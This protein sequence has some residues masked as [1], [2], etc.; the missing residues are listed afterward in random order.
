M[1]GIDDDLIY[2]HSKRAI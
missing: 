2:K 1:Q